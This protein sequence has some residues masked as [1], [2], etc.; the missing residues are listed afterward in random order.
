MKKILI[1]NNNLHIGG[2]QKALINLLWQL[3][4]QYDVTLLL[5]HKG[6]KYLEDTAIW[7]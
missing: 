4:G 6:G 5:F 3:R 2:V 1:V 7:E